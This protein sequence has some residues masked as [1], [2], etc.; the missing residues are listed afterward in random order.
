M[1]NSCDACDR[2]LDDLPL[3]FPIRLLDNE[4]SPNSYHLE[5]G[6]PI[7]LRGWRPAVNTVCISIM[8]RVKYA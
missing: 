1:I 6:C 2:K 4:D 7:G 5:L 8:I 3:V